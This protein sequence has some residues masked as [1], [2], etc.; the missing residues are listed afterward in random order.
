MDRPPPATTL[1]EPIIPHGGIPEQLGRAASGKGHARATPAQQAVALA[2]LLRR[3]ASWAVR[4]SPS[5]TQATG[6]PAL[7]RPPLQAGCH[8]GF[9]T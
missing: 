9:V 1:P 2:S 4:H 5:E 6:T 7:Q 8:W 3:A